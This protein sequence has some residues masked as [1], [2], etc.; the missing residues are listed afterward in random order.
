MP[1]SV[2][3]GYQAPGEVWRDQDGLLAAALIQ[4]EADLCPG[5]GHP[6]SE[7]TDRENDPDNRHGSHRYDA[8]DPVRCF[9]CTVVEAKASAYAESRQPRA[10]RFGTVRVPRVAG[11]R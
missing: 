6:L 3:R 1:L 9:A 10:L 11:K 5:C 8:L 7:S 4:Y 2:L